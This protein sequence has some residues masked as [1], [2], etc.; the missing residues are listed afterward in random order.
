MEKIDWSKEWEK[1]LNDDMYIRLCE[2]RNRKSDLVPM[3]KVVKKLTNKN[4][5]DAL[6]YILEWVCDLNG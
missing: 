2:C 5:E 4:S 3:A 6:I 1:N